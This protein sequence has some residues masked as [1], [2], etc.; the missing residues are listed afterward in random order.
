MDNT[1]ALIDTC[2]YWNCRD[3]SMHDNIV[4]GILQ[5][6]TDAIGIAEILGY[7]RFSIAYMDLVTYNQAP[8]HEDKGC[9][10]IY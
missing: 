8:L 9:R 4:I 6:A 2:V 10:C 1:T 3:Y 5:Y 7:I